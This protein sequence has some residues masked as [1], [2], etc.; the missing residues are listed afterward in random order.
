M[1]DDNHRLVSLET[2]NFIHDSRSV[3]LSSALVASSMT[4]TSRS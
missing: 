2:L 3:S 1:S 4:S